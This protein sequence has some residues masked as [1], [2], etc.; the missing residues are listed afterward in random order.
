VVNGVKGEV[1]LASSRHLP[2][3]EIAPRVHAGAP[4]E[5]G[6]GGTPDF[7]FSGGP[8]RGGGEAFARAHPG[9][10]GGAGNQTGRPCIP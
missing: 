3:A 10:G 8:G 4:R 2:P 6:P 1:I 9:R 7:L 5:P